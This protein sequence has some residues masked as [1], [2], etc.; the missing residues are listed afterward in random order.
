MLRAAK[1]LIAGLIGMTA[2]MLRCP[3]HDTSTAH[4]IS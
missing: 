1:H 2:R 3:Q 4:D